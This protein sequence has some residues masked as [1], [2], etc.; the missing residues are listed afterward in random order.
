[1]KESNRLYDNPEYYDVAFSYRDLAR[2]VA[3]FDRCIR[4]YSRIPVKRVLEFGAGTA[5]H[6]EEWAKRK[7]EYVGIEK[8][9]KMLS[10]AREK[11]KKLGASATLVHADMRFFAIDRRVDFAYTM[12]GSLFVETTEDIDSH[13]DSVA[14]ALAPGG[15]Y[16]LDWCVNFEWAGSFTAEQSWT[17]EKADVKV[18]TKFRMEAVD[19]AAQTVRQTI[20]AR[21]TDGSK[22]LWLDSE[23]VVRA[24]F[25]QEFLL[26]VERNSKFEF[27]G[28]WNH[29]NLDEPIAKSTTRIS[30][31]IILLR[32]K[33]L[34]A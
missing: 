4:E 21:V 26:L 6:M 24:I 25:P 11:A 2:E 14:K 13:F 3:V 1:M 34:E 16:L 30:R 12:L 32:R 23:E 5:P 28:W 8:N 22:V 17:T 20:T 31:P 27:L 19:R 33:P 9:E 18:E 29:W 10:Y 7:I 15:L